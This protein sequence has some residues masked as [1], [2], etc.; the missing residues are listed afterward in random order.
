MA[1]QIISRQLINRTVGANTDQV[2]AFVPM[3]PGTRL[4]NVWLDVSVQANA[5]GTIEAGYMYGLSGFVV[6]VDDPD[7]SFSYDQ[8]WDSMINKDQ[9]EAFGGIDLDTT[10][11]VTTPEFE[12]GYI[13]LF[14]IFGDNLVGNMQIY[15]KRELLTY[16]KRPVGYDPSNDTY[17]AQDAFKVHI[18]NGPK[19]SKP[20]V[21]MFGF[22]SPAMDRTQTINNFVISATPSEK[23]WLFTMYAEVFLYDMWKHLIGVTDSSSDEPYNQVSEWFAKLLEDKMYEET[24]TSRFL[25]ADWIV[26][27][28]ATWDISVVG[29]PGKVS[30][31]SD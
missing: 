23:Q 13:D 24:N 4:N 28:K 31:T 7:T 14:Q 22:S 15:Q 30:L 12:V 5:A 27:T 1:S 20:S 18:K 9:V 25:P 3:P 2:T 17:Y 6:S 11:S 16:P 29:K 21:A 8:L 19:V 10:T 26:H